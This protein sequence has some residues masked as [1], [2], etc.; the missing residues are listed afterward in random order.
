M[1]VLLEIKLIITDDN[2]VFAYQVSV[3]AFYL[4][5]VNLARVWHRSFSYAV[6][7][8]RAGCRLQL[9]PCFQVSHREPLAGLRQKVMVLRHAD[10]VATLEQDIVTREC[11]LVLLNF[12]NFAKAVYAAVNLPLSNL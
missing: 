9:F 3:R 5:I 7:L 8:N 11:A 4:E 10:A 12:L 1:I 6:N 2:C